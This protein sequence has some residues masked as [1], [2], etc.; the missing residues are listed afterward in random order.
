MISI[1]WKW[2]EAKGQ[3]RGFRALQFIS[4]FQRPDFSPNDPSIRNCFHLTLFVYSIQSVIHSLSLELLLRLE[5]RYPWILDKV[6][7]ASPISILSK[8]AVDLNRGNVRG[9]DLDAGIC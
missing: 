2:C 7:W 9:D 8:N 4:S 3:A 5:C 1:D 6:V